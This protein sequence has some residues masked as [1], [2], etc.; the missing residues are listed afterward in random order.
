MKDFRLASRI[1][2]KAS[3]GQTLIKAFT[4]Q[5]LMKASTDQI[6]DSRIEKHSDSRIEKPTPVKIRSMISQVK[7]Q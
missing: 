4:V 1:P 2:M 5:I 7:L 6:S 3:T